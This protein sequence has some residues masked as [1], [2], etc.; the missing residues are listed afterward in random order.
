MFKGDCVTG[1]WFVVYT[2]PR[3]EFRALE[4][5]QRQDYE[6]FLPLIKVQ[7]I[8]VGKCIDVTESL[9]PRYFF[10]RLFEGVSNFAP[11]RSTRGGKRFGQVFRFPR[12]CIR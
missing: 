4:N 2:Q 8:R 6:C 1:K 11:I 12:S 10:I 7:K 9:F 3:Q 5:L